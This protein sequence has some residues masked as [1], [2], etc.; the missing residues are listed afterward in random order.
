MRGDLGS[1]EIAV[2]VEGLLPER[3]PGMECQR[4]AD[5]TPEIAN[6]LIS[7]PSP[8]RPLLP[9]RG[10]LTSAKH[11]FQGR[12]YDE[13]CV[14]HDESEADWQDVIAA[15]VLEKMPNTF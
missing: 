3:S 5:T 12:P 11:N 4:G 1:A 6:R 2:G 9:Q 10:P 15:A 14:E 8:L 7:I 13:L